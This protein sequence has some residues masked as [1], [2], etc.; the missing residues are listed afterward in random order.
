MFPLLLISRSPRRG[1]G[2]SQAIYI[3]GNKACGNIY[4]RWQEFSNTTRSFSVGIARNGGQ[5]MGGVRVSLPPEGLSQ[6][7]VLLQVV[8]KKERD[9]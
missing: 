6:S 3:Q 8:R 4:N 2:R 5:M 7:L 1:G 9:I